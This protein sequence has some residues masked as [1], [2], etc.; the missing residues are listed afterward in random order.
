M[1]E[2]TEYTIDPPIADPLKLKGFCLY[3][4]NTLKYHE[5]VK[6][7]QIPLIWPADFEEWWNQFNRVLIQ[8]FESY[9]EDNIHFTCPYDLEYPEAFF[10]LEDPPLLISYK[11]L[12]IWNTHKVMGVVGSRRPVGATKLW[13]RE[14]FSEFLKIYKDR[15]TI[16]K[17]G[18]IVSG[19]AKGVDQLAHF[20]CLELK[21]PTIVVVPSG[22]NELYPKDLQDW[23]AEVIKQGGVIVSEYFLNQPMR[24]FHFLNRNRLIAAFSKSGIFIPQ[25]EVR[26]G[27]MI[28]ALRSLEMNRLLGAIPPHPTLVGFSGNQSLLRTGATIIFD[29]TDLL[30]FSAQNNQ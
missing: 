7:R 6:Q 11:G 27:T 19:G 5:M 2:S 12:P 15:P 21:V 4:R 26:G 22:L 3:A 30:F 24:K 9:K 8:R 14:E 1:N 10:D 29:R 16:H 17:P 13:M 18:A 25:C 28:T 20:Q 23:G